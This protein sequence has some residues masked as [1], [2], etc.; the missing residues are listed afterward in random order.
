MPDQKRDIFVAPD[1]ARG[2]PARASLPNLNVCGDIGLKIGADGTW[3][4]EG[5]PIKRKPLVKLFA[6]V[7][8]CEGEGNYFL[9][10][11]V[12]KVPIEVADLPFVAVEMFKEGEGSEQRLSFRTNVDDVVIA[13]GEH[14]LG[15]QAAATGAPLPY[16]VVRNGLKAR[17]ARSVYYE[18]AALAVECPEKGSMGVWSGGAFF[19]FPATGA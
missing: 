15:F 4:Y 8:R 9:V 11:P 6:S 16:V 3:Y 7:L 2:K 18:L 14:R 13:D 19:A 1:D 17:L 10:T 12:E 5:T